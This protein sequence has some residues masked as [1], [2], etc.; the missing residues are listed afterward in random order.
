MRP[1]VARAVLTVFVLLQLGLRPGP[2]AATEVFKWKD[3]A[4]HLHFG[5]KPPGAAVQAESVT[6][7]SSAPVAADGQRQ[8]RLRQL[9]DSYA[10]ERKAKDASRAAA[11]REVERREQ[12]C[13][14][15]RARR[16]QAERTNVMYVR[17]PGGERRVLDG[18]EHQHVI[19][20]ARQA[21]ADSC[22]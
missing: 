4:G 8:E 13:T 9:L 18:A 1:A 14:R 6:V 2:L 7:R 16:Q 12:A 21:V 19:D 5:D 17:T 15:A 3:A 22:D 10:S 20:K 11:R